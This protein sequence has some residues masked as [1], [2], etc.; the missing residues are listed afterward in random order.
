MVEPLFAGMSDELAQR[1]HMFV[2]TAWKQMQ[3]QRNETACR[4]QGLV[5]EL[6]AARLQTNTREEIV[7]KFAGDV[8]VLY[9][10]VI[11][12]AAKQRCSRIPLTWPTHIFAW[13][14][15]SNC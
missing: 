4:V 10:T 11:L 8:D 2:V 5:V 15:C 14:C 3:L 13:V 1:L 9:H 12:L 7:R 6:A